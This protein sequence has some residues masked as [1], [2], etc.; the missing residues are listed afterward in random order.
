M[1]IPGATNIDHVAYTVPDLD[2]AVAFFTNILGADLIYREGPIHDPH[3]DRMT[4]QLNVH[5]TAS[6]RIAMLRLGPVTNLE[7]FQYEAP[8]QRRLLPANSDW[9]GHHLAFHVTDIEAAAHYLSRQP[10][11]RLLGSPRTVD[12]GPIAGN[13]WVYFLTPWGM[14]MELVQAS[15]ALP[16]ESTTRA[17]R[18]GPAPAWHDCVNAVRTTDSPEA[19]HA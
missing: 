12:D 2:Q 14:Q 11:V 15:P 8:G 17:R 16:Y 10:G 9:G 6:C 18:Y 1:S 5:P 7:L 4:Q 19:H 3:G 13:R